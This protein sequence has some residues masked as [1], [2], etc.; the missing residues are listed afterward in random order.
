MSVTVF[1]EL[2]SK[3]ESRDELKATFKNILPETRSFEGCLHVEVKENQEDLCNLVLIEKW[4]S[5]QHHEKYFEWRAE[6]GAIEAL[7]TML[8][9]PPVI[10]YFFDVD[11]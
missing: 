4:D 5:R 2:Q 7:G 6:T 1:L 3:P 8:A 11:I 9:Q 10:R